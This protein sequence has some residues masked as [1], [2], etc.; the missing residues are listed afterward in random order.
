MFV[1]STSNI[2]IHLV[3]LFPHTSCF[4][5]VSHL[6]LHPSTLY[7]SVDGLSIV[8]ISGINQVLEFPYNQS[9]E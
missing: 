2:Y 3:H 7:T 4:F 8:F 6:A 9:E 5:N 1:G